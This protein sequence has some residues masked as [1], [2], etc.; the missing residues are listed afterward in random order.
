MNDRKLKFKLVKVIGSLIGILWMDEHAQQR[1]AIN[2]KFIECV[3][4][5][6]R[7]FKRS[8]KVMNGWEGLDDREKDNKGKTN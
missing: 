1:Q 6:C 5:N 7:V 8:M 3:W 2:A 4:L